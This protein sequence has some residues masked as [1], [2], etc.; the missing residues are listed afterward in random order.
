MNDFIDIGE[1]LSKQ[2]IA[3]DNTNPEPDDVCCSICKGYEFVYARRDDGSVDYSRLV[4][5]SC[6][7]DK[8]AIGQRLLKA[9]DVPEARR[10]DTF[11]TL[12]PHT[13]LKPALDA[14]LALAR[15]EASFSMLVLEGPGGVGKTHLLYAS[16]IHRC[17]HLQNVA[18]YTTVRGLLSKMQM[19]MSAEG[20][21]AEHVLNRY[22]ETPFLAIDEIGKQHEGPSGWA[23]S[24]FEILMDSRYASKFPTICAT[25]YEVANFPDSIR[26]RLQDVVQCR[27]IRIMAGDYRLK[28]RR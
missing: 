28:E 6:A 26:S 12:I 21:S 20:T 10:G 15:G 22:I 23:Y 19:A 5:C 1:V 25:N 24:A 9:S 3:G 8:S 13:R 17:L 2:V 18:R 27:I 14:S 16:C 7:R 11:E 4:P